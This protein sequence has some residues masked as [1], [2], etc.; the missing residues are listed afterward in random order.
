VVPVIAIARQNNSYNKVSLGQ[1]ADHTEIFS[2]GN[3]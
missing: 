1:K 3:Y 2:G